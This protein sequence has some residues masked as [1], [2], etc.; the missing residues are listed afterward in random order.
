MKNKEG[1]FTVYVCLFLLVLISAVGIFISATKETAIKGKALA[2]SRLW[3]Q[4]VLAEYDLN[5]QQRY[6]IFGYYGYPSMIQN[7]LNFYAGETFDGKKNADLKILSC[8]LYEHS[9]R[10][11]EVFGRQ[12]A[13]CGKLVLTNAFDKPVEAIKSVTRHQK[14]EKQ[15]L[16]SDLPSEGSK[17]GLSVSSLIQSY[18]AANGLKDII[19]KGTD[20]YFQ[21]AYI[22]FYFKN[23]CQ[24]NDLGKTCLA[25]ETEYIIGGKR[26]DEANENIIRRRIIAL[27]EGINLT[28]LKADPEKTAA[29]Y[30]AA[31]LLTPGA[32][33]VTA[34]SM[35]ALWAYAESVNDYKLL[36]EGYPVAKLKTADNW[37]TDLESVLAEDGTE[38]C[39]YTG[40]Q[41]GDTYEDY[42]RL[43]LVTMNENTRLLRMMDLIQINMRYSY[44]D[45]FSMG[46]YYGGVS[47]SYT[48]NG[49]ICHVE[50]TYE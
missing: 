13:S 10:N 37:A 43:L 34:Q 23:R 15:I 31:E 49:E 19:K 32:V 3:S 8:S 28:A 2:C 50:D 20:T 12:A 42:L 39:I 5:L 45:S 38:G 33:P 16:F 25:Y 4:S 18:D 11:V 27:R 14:P 24:Q 35:M 44:Y 48:I 29:V 30:A 1:F 40:E 9:L 7:K 6:H 46:D 17:T 26:S 21:L 41:A 22:F 36:T 47:Y